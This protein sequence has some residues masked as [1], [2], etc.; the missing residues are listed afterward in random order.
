M[1]TENKYIVPAFILSV[2]FVI[3][4]LIIGEAWRNHTRTNQTITVTGSAKRMIV[5]DLGIIRA[6]LNAQAAQ[7][8]DSYRDIRNQIPP[9]KEY[10]KSKGISIDSLEFY[11]P[12]N[13]P[14][15]E[16]TSTGI[17]TNRIIGYVWNQNFS[18]MSKDVAKIKEISLELSQLVERGVNLQ[19]IQPEY[20]Y[21]K[22]AE[23]KIE[24]QS[25]AAKDAMERARKIA[26]A[27]GSK[28]GRLRSARMGVLQITP[29]F[30]NMISD[31]G[32]NDLSS[33]EKEITA[34]VNAAFEIR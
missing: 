20:H 30:S 32:I 2:F 17:Q 9:L 28:L 27:T 12:T 19:N 31:Y 34:V 8:Q 23:L 10:L 11:A 14:I 26:E 4:V 33:I 15:Y 24:I 29:R 16:F 13:Y 22:L 5:S 3:G 1:L 6:N 21:T 7:L 18:I 25:E